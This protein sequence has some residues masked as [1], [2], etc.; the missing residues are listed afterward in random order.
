MQLAGTKGRFPNT[1]RWF[2]DHDS[3]AHLL[4]IRSARGLLV[5]VSI[6]C[7]NSSPYQ[8]QVCFADSLSVIFVKER[9]HSLQV[10]SHLKCD[11]QMFQILAVQNTVFGGF[12]QRHGTRIKRDRKG[13]S[14]PVLSLEM[15]EAWA[16][17]KWVDDANEVFGFFMADSAT[18][19]KWGLLCPDPSEDLV[20]PAPGIAGGQ[21]GSAS[22]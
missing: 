2:Q 21:D 10:A 3:G 14:S 13:L 22:A 20:A 1:C 9:G 11:D 12:R 6:L 17:G 4:T 7:Q 8:H 18:F 5:D 19:W 16:A 15:R